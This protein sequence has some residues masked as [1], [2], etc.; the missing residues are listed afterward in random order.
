MEL[1]SGFDALIKHQE[2]SNQCKF[3]NEDR[4]DVN[5][6]IESFMKF[7]KNTIANLQQSSSTATE[8]NE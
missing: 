7:V 8:I 5:D 2:M 3:W 6:L 4:F 1:D